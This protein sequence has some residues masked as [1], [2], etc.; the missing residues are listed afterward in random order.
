MGG[1]GKKV[2]TKPAILREEGACHVNDLYYGSGPGLYITFS[3]W[4]ITLVKMVDTGA[5]YPG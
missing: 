5:G 2:E 1:M 4:H 3:R